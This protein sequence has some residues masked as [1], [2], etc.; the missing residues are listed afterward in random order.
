M[1][2]PSK[3]RLFGKEGSEAP[4]ILFI[5]WRFGNGLVYRDGFPET[6]SYHACA[7]LLLC[8][9]FD[10]NGDPVWERR[11]CRREVEYLCYSYYAEPF[12]PAT[13]LMG[14]CSARAN[15]AKQWPSK[16]FSTNKTG[17]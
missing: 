11:E 5:E 1:C 2:L 13:A 12:K 9:P 10:R 14:V 3:A 7:L 15:M 8:A 17:R 6:M 16:K 4:F